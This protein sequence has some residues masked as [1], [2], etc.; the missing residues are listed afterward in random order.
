STEA[1]IGERIEKMKGEVLI[2]EPFHLF[3]DG[4]LFSAPGFLAADQGT[5]LLYDPVVCH[6]NCRLKVERN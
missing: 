2:A 3:N 6:E 5:V 1:S 4:N